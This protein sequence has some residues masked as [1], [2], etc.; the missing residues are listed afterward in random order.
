MRL[1]KNNNSNIIY[2]IAANNLLAKK[3]SSLISLLSI[4]LVTALICVL[5][6]FILGQ[7]TKET[8]GNAGI[9]TIFFVSLLFFTA[10]SIVIYSI[11]YFS[12]AARARQIGQFLTIGMTEKQVKKM[13]RREGLLLSVIAIPA[14]LLLGGLVICIAMPEGWDLAEYGTVSLVI[15]ALEFLIV[16]ISIGKPASMAS[17]VSP[18]EASKYN[19]DAGRGDETG[20]K[21]H[22]FLSPFTLAQMEI[23]NNPKRLGLTTMSLALGGILFMVAATWI[24]S[25]DREAFSRQGVF[26]DCEYYLEYSY[27]PHGAPKA[28]GITD[29]Q[30][31]GT[32]SDAL[33]EEIRAIP[34]VKDV[35]IERT[36]TG[37]ISY[38]GAVFT[39]P[40]CPLSSEDAE[41][42]ELPAE[43]HNS[44][45]Y[46]ARHDAI[47]ITD[48]GFC[49]KVNGI[50]FTPGEKL[51]IS[52]FDGEEHT[53]ELEIAAVTKEK[54]ASHPERTTFCM[55]DATMKK[56]WAG[57]NT[58]QSFSISVDNFEENG[59][60]AEE[61]LRALV[62]RYDDLSLRTLREQKLEDAAQIPELEMQIYGI[63]AFV[64]MFGV[65]HLVNTVCGS[66]M[67]RKKQLSM[68]E[69]VGMEERQVRNM[70]LSESFFLTLPNILL[71]IT[72]GSAAGFGFIS[73]MQK[74][75]SYLEYRFPVAA[76]LLYVVGMVAIPMIITIVCLK[77]QQKYSLVERIRNED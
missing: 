45:A 24:A 21:K 13:I 63:A 72:L 2:R 61:Q 39:Q 8:Q 17:K 75:A 1:D 66:I 4:L 35:H 23:R 62:S 59:A 5:S 54:A 27:D 69:S 25:W 40:F 29:F 67:S 10:S 55:S 9:Y 58:A 68:L 70:L 19:M 12:V 3:S 42:F 37:V 65:F 73:M 28:Y 64:I 71:T 57:M 74:S 48:S 49:E 6:L 30:R 18:I 76:I 31:K 22:K 36:A 33:A 15:A 20:K 26:R 16:Q 44:Y 53:I 43:G 50:A 41:Y 52:Y 38:Q 11:F 46:M 60:Q 7:R 34:H 56:L 77:K 47:F 14:G 32:L 51:Q